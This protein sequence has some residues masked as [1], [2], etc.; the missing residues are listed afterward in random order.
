MKAKID[1]GDL[2]AYKLEFQ[3]DDGTLTGNPIYGMVVS[4]IDGGTIFE[5]E[6]LVEWFSHDTSQQFL[7]DDILRLKRYAEK[8]KKKVVERSR[9]DVVR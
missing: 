2:V 4:I 6:Y 8:E 5:D 9:E 3:L 1:V 7:R